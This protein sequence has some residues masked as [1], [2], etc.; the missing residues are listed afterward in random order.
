MG[1]LS[2]TILFLFLI[3]VCQL[4]NRFISC[5]PVSVCKFIAWYG[6]ATC[7]YFFLICVVDMAN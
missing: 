5:F 6:V 3:M 7:L 2:N 4:S 1:P